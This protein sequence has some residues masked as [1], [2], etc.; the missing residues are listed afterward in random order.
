MT[1]FDRRRPQRQGN[2]ACAERGIVLSL[3]AEK[4]PGSSTRAPGLSLRRFICFTA[5]FAY[6]PKPSRLSPG[7]V[8]S[9]PSPTRRMRTSHGP[10]EGCR[11]A[12]RGPRSP[13]ATQKKKKKK[14]N[15]RPDTGDL[16]EPLACLGPG[17]AISVRPPRSIATICCSYPSHSFPENAD[18]VAQCRGCSGIRRQSALSRGSRARYP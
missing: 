15:A 2:R 8:L 11:V 12:N 3:D 9:W 16:S 10:Y 5:A 13:V 17:K 18:E 6:A 1:T 7:R 14:N 4:R